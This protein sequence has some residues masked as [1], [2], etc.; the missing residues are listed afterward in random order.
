M[1]TFLPTSSA[2]HSLQL[3]PT[4]KDDR[5]NLNVRTGSALILHNSLVFT[6]GGL[7]VGLDLADKIDAKHILNTFLLKLGPNKLKK[8]RKYLSG[9]LFYLDLLSKTW[10]R[11][12]L[13]EQALRPKPRL[14]HEMAKG[15]NCIYIF[16]GLVFPDDGD[17]LTD[18][19]ASRLVPC[20]DLWQFDLRSK[21]WSRLHDGLEVSEG[22]PLPR[23]CHK[24]TLINT[25]HF[26]RKKDHCGLIIAGGQGADSRP[27][28]DNF[29][30]DLVEKKYVDAGNPLFFSASSGDKQKDQD[31]GLL[32]FDSVSKDKNVNVNYLN[33][34]IVNFS[35]EVEHHHHHL[36]RHTHGHSERRESKNH[37]PIVQDISTAEEESIILYSPTTESLDNP[38][39]NPLLSFRIGKR[40]CRGKVMPLHNKR[41]NESSFSEQ[42]ANI[43]RR[44]VPHNLSFPTGGL[45]GQNLV[46][47]GF[48]PNDLDISIFIYNKPTGKWSRLNI[49]CHHDY[50]S[51]RFWGGF[52]WTSHHK[53]VLLGNYVTSRTTSSVRYFSSMITV[54]LPVTNILASFEMA[55]SH[56]HGPDGKKYLTMETSSA[57]EF[58]SASSSAEDTSSLSELDDDD[59]P[60]FNPA[61]KFSTMSSKSDSKA[62]G[63]NRSFNEYVHYAA[64]KVNYT[65]IRSVFPPAAIT[66]GRSAFDR[67]GDM[68]SDLELISTSGDRIPISMTVLRERWGKY[69][70]DLLAKAYV[71][72]VDKFE[73]DQLQ[74][75]TSQKLR[76]SRSSGGSLESR[77]TRHGASSDDVSSNEPLA[78]RPEKTFHV[79]IPSVKPSQKEPPQFR[80][81][82]QEASSTTSLGSKDTGSIDPHKKVAE[83]KASVSSYSSTNSL[84]ASQLQD[85]PPQLPM[86][87][88]PLPA[89]PATPTTFKPGSRKNST[90]ATSPRASL[91]HTLTV[92]RNI[93]SHGG[94]SPR[95]SPFASPRGSVSASLDQQVTEISV[96]IMSKTTSLNK[97]QDD[98]LRMP[99]DTIDFSSERRTSSSTR[100]S[101]NSD[102]LMKKN[103]LATLT[104]ETPAT[105]RSLHEETLEDEDTER[106]HHHALLDFDNNDAESFKMEPSLI[107]RKLY[108]PFCTSSLKAFAEYMYTGQVGNKWTLRP[109]LLDCML[110]AR[111]F[112]VPLLYDLISEVLYG[113]IGRKEAHIIKEGKRLKKKYFE[114]FQDLGRHV[115]LNLRLPIDEYE[116]FMDT[117]DDGYLDIALLRKSSSLH[118]ASVSSQGSKKR[119][120]STPASIPE[121]KTNFNDGD[122]FQSRSRRLG[123]EEPK[124]PKSGQLEPSEVTQVEDSKSEGD[125]DDDIYQSDIHFLDFSDDRNFGV[126]PRSKSVFDRL[127][128]DSVTYLTTEGDDEEKEKSL[129]TTLEVLVSPDSPPPSDY[130][131]D[132]IHGIAS[133]CTDVKLM[134]RALNVKHMSKALKQTEQDYEKL[135]RLARQAQAPEDDTQLQLTVSQPGSGRPSVATL[136]PASGSGNVTPF[137]RTPTAE[138]SE[139]GPS[140]TQP[141]SM[142]SSTSLNTT[143]SAFKFTPLKS[144]TTGGRTNSKSLLEDNKD[145]DKRIAQIIRQEEKTKLKAA[146][147]EKQRAAKEGKRAAKEAKR[148]EREKVEK[149]EPELLSQ[150]TLKHTATPLERN[151][152]EPQNFYSSRTRD[153]DA[154]SQYSKPSI[155]S[156][157]KEKKS[158]I[159]L[160]IGHKFRHP[161]PLKQADSNDSDVRSISTTRSSSSQTSSSSKKSSRR[162]GFFGLRKRN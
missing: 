118:K 34:V 4:E 17:E 116:G 37:G 145:L 112:K 46:I 119:N 7:T 107:P 129:L 91:L 70:I 106:H 38:D 6:F 134:L 138:L 99:S 147:E 78:D 117:V 127:A 14:F 86:P 15:N 12:L 146:K 158:G 92:L 48:L 55:G 120:T 45:F 2:C 47:V 77:S 59:I 49:F 9:E 50:G 35:E 159:M 39:V 136:R 42:K 162:T 11:V 126:N 128:Y 150:L 155:A 52:A 154:A 64:P 26:A 151:S 103:S 104:A 114:C 74:S 121:E 41:N 44:T 75:E 29:A 133:V 68:M 58:A 105:A 18:E 21:S 79:S 123:S 16:G 125:E 3:P 13:P 153:D 87:N 25:L 137:K 60:D 84:L 82:F 27:L 141:Q 130:V 95:A 143:T 20:N 83:R 140:N 19:M 43:L 131:I 94:K 142:R 152:T 76:A 161:E 135:A 1:T 56:F 148:A 149:K 71:G 66:L 111:Y 101:S 10:L 93:P 36:H 23:Y 108:I 61:R 85:I 24:M 65:K 8:I 31:S 139:L 157:T 62:P 109:C 156:T 89:V 124:S 144:S 22:V 110:I 28:Y 63:N 122:Y 160:R 40:I 132:L 53:V 113:I 97:V 102:S 69:F 88:E 33:S 98:T 80:L 54:S 32:Q 115:D 81:P 73:F 57:E 51:H 100:T 30:Y 96:P 67:Y 72:A 90:D 5:L